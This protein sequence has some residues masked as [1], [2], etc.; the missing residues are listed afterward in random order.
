MN[1][2]PAFLA[3]DPQS[4]EAPPVEVDLTP[5]ETVAQDALFF[6]VEVGILA[7]AIAF[8]LC[9][10]RLVK[11]PNL[12]DRGLAADVLSFQVVGLAILLTIRL[13]TLMFFDAVL[14]VSILGF[15]ST[16]A[17]AQFIGRRRAV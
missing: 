5:A 1:W 15:A 10:W 4:T 7:L 6:V 14:I 8:A 3:A 11:G 2:A 17:F 13:R 12:A 9:V 16:I